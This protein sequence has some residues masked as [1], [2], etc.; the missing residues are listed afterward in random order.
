MIKRSA[1]I[2]DNLKILFIE[3]RAFGGGAFAKKVAKALSKLTQ[4][5]EIVMI[6]APTGSNITTQPVKHV[7][8]RHDQVNIGINSDRE[9]DITIKRTY[10]RLNKLTPRFNNI[11]LDL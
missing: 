9:F 2:D 10:G 11:S 3:K 4:I 8:S 7:H 5:L 6:D 1:C